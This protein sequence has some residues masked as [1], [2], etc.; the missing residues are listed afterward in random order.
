MLYHMRVRTKFNS[1][2]DKIPIKNS[3]ICWLVET[4]YVALKHK[5]EVKNFLG[6]SEDAVLWE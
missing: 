3:S 5:S 2:I 4:K 6:R 1:D